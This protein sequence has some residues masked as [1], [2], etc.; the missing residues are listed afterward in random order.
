MRLINV[1]T[2]QLEEFFGEAIPPYAI[3]SHTWGDGE[4][5]YQ[6]WQNLEAASKK[7][8]WPKITGACRKAIR[9]DLG[10]LWVDTNC[11]DKTSSAELT[12]A[13]NSMFDWY[14][15]SEVCF[16]LLVDVELRSEAPDME[17]TLRQIRESR[18]FTRGWTLQELL[19]PSNLIFYDKSW[20]KLGS[21]A[22]ALLAEVSVT[23]GIQIQFLADK[24]SAQKASVAQKMSWL[25]R[26]KTTHTEDIAYCMMGLFGIN[27]PLL[28][29][30]GMKAFTRLQEEIIR[31][32]NDH[33][34]FCWSW[35]DSLSTTEALSSMLAPTPQNFAHGGQ[36]S[37][38]RTV[39]LPGSA[40]RDVSI[41]SMTNAG[42]SI[43]LPILYMGTSTMLS[44][45]NATTSKDD[46]MEGSSR[47]VVGIP[48]Y[49]KRRL[50]QIRCARLSFPSDP[51]RLTLDFCG[52][53]VDELLLVGQ[54]SSIHHSLVPLIDKQLSDDPA[55]ERIGI[56][57]AAETRDLLARNPLAVDRCLVHENLGRRCS[58]AGPEVWIFSTEITTSYSPET[59]RATMQKVAWG[60]RK[61]GATD[62]LEWFCDVAYDR[63]PNE[64]SIV[65]SR[66]LHEHQCSFN[67][68]SDISVAIGR[69]QIRVEGFREVRLLYVSRGR[70][71]YRD[72][73]NRPGED[74]ESGVSDDSD[75]SDIS[76]RAGFNMGMVAGDVHMFPEQG[77]G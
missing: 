17:D 68:L 56:I 10:W 58:G 64:Q 46:T 35:I 54:S 32:S 47:F 21:K 12:E 15:R 22:G 6:D 51:V 38:R 2:L 69:H 16:A 25:S 24:L 63:W 50:H 7:A 61:L 66:R 65:R 8:A 67:R 77:L 62:G 36:Y 74:R 19:A 11:I 71:V 28:Y 53:P 29:G 26:R 48:L 37:S 75:A 4:V 43:Q 41:Y 31:T 39:Q 9:Y 5:T 20:T 57:F 55:D 76:H 1:H 18:W 13:I 72:Q 34:I 23:T 14:A 3:L 40:P 73:R 45:L 52:N 42:L 70:R 59:L 33:T 49:G 44:I 30:E 27:M 60:A